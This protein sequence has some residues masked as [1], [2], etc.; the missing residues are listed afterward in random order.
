MKN[1]KNSS[2]KKV[3]GLGA[4]AAAAAA[5][6]YFYGSKNAAKNRKNV[7]DFAQ[8][9]KKEVVTKVAKLKEVTKANYEMA[10]A[11]VLENYKKVKNINPKELIALS[12]ELK[13]HWQKITQHLP[14]TTKTVVKK[15]TPAKT[16]RA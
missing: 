6:Y 11:E 13:S 7:S 5:T 10:V 1:Q 3:L 2:G 15:K 9:A 14:K 12:Q 16:K 8:K 4:L